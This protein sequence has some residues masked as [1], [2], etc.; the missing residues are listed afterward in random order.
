[1]ADWPLNTVL[2]DSVSSTYRVCNG[3]Q[4]EIQPEL[5]SGGVTP[6]RDRRDEAR[7]HRAEQ[8]LDQ[9]R[10]QLVRVL[11]QQQPLLAHGLHSDEKFQ[12]QQFRV[13]DR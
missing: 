12:V 8:A 4:G 6:L 3:D 10:E 11:L 9:G 2:D 13:T 1:M 5:P 7:L